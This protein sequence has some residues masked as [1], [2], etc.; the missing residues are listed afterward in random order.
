MMK[1]LKTVGSPVGCPVAPAA[2]A[3]VLPNMFF[4]L[5]WDPVR[6]PTF[7]PN[8]FPFGLHLADP[9]SAIFNQ[10]VPTAIVNPFHAEDGRGVWWEPSLPVPLAAARSALEYKGKKEEE[11]MFA[12]SCGVHTK[13]C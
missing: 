12:T 1:C 7:F 3:L 2:W 5:P 9:V 4:G 6:L 10:E 11:G 13:G 8:N